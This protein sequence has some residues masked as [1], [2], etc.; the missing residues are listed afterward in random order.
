MMTSLQEIS[1]FFERIK[2]KESR[3]DRK[4]TSKRKK[5]APAFDEEEEFVIE[6]DDFEEISDLPSTSKSKTYSV[7]HFIK[8]FGNELPKG[9]Q[10]FDFLVDAWYHGFIEVKQESGRLRDRLSHIVILDNPT[11]QLQLGFD[12]DE[13]DFLDNYYIFEEFAKELNLFDK[14][15]SLYLQKIQELFPACLLVAEV[16]NMP[17]STVEK[18]IFVRTIARYVYKGR[19]EYME[20]E[21]FKKFCRTKQY[22]K[23]ANE[24]M[25]DQHFFLVE[26]Y[27]KL[28][29]DPFLGNSEIVLSKKAIQ[30]VVDLGDA[31]NEKPKSNDFEFFFPEDVQEVALYFDETTQKAVDRLKTILH[32]VPQ[33]ELG[34]MIC[35]F[36]GTSGGGKTELSRNIFKQLQIPFI[37]IGSLA[38]KYVG[39]SEAK[40]KK[41]FTKEYPK[42]VEKY[43]RVGIIWN[44]VDQIA[45]KK[46]D[47]ERSSDN[48]NNAIVSYLLNILDGLENCLM[49]CSMNNSKDR[50]EPA[51]LR[52]MNYQIQFGLPDKAARYQ[53]WKSNNNAGFWQEDEAL[54]NQ[55]ADYPFSGADIANI[56]AKA[57][58]FKYFEEGQAMD[59]LMEV[60]DEQ[61]EIAKKS[62]Y[63]FDQSS[64]GIGFR[65]VG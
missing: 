23:F 22:L 63:H 51:V 33:A 62:R 24:L 56:C 16:E 3:I 7:S 29:K 65:K 2:K 9:E 52:R 60:V 50:C 32:K 1:A 54:L 55:L 26:N 61:L 48:I 6:I 25:T 31:E 39:D 13:V 43:G 41:I 45:F 40:L 14:L 10:A 21:N 36:E 18:F 37:Q 42:L 59:L 12:K 20:T 28:V 17:V 34:K 53:I 27:W 46:T 15:P 4:S 11:S 5:P 57:K 58:F 49:I 47:A 64:T 44:E 38:S 19:A 8:D 30:L 35:L